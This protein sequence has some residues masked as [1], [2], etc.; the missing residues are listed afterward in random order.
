MDNS[1]THSSLNS[2]LQVVVGVLIDSSQ[3]VLMTQRALYLHQGGL[4]EFPGGKVEPGESLENALKREFQEE[5]AIV[6]EEFKPFTSIIHH[7]PDKAV[8]LHVYLITQYKGQPKI[9]DGQL[10]IKWIDLKSWAHK[11]FPIPASNVSIV[12]M[13]LESHTFRF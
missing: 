10:D 5:I 3:K 6:I 1:R 13:L 12:N 11:D 8:Q 2:P 4:W 7:Y 9:S